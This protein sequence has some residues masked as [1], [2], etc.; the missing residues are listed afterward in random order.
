M[1]IKRMLHAL[2]IK[3]P[4]THERSL[5]ESTE[6]HKSGVQISGLEQDLP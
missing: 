4:P 3:G 1:S 6:G 2:H 5:F